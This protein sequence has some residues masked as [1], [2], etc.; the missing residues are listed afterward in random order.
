MIR[1]S[2]RGLPPLTFAFGI[3]LILETPVVATHY[4]TLGVTADASTG[5]IR[6]AYH[7]QA[8]QWHP[9]RF[10][11]KAPLEAKKAEDRMRKLN[12]A[13]AVLGDAGSRKSY[14]RE[15]AGLRNNA[16]TVGEAVQTDGGIPRIDPRLLDPE[17]LAS[18]RRLMEEDT[19]VH[20]S[21]I[22][23]TITVVGFFA[24]LGGIFIFT[25]YANGSSGTAPSTTFPA[26][27]LGIGIEAGSCVRFMSEG[28]MQERE[29]DGPNDGRILGVREDATSAACPAAT[30]RQ[31]T[32]PNELIV[33]LGE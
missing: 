11:G 9:D 25:A 33:C 13:W 21:G 28:A 3:L 19:E 6:K 15:L 27:D 8:R 14:D 1:S 26:P 22:L 30:V 17:F 16:T 2:G 24:L 10:V 20:H 5:E 7:D 29:C 12:D 4:K 18:R 32:L 23:R 31:V